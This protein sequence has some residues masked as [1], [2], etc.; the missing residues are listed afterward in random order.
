MLG[1]KIPCRGSPEAPSFSGRPEDLR[2][3]FD[4]IID[5]CD[6]FGLSDGLARIKF[7]LKYA[8]FESADLWS[9]FVSSSQGDWARFTLEITQQYP[10]LDETSRSHADELASLK[11]GFASSEVVSMSSL[12]QYYRNF[13]RISLSLENLLGPL[14]HLASMFKYGFPP[15]FRRELRRS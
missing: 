4:D 8:P 3:Y 15:E 7:A 12:G 9:H 11:V 14:P 1:F 10:E 6:G 13:R 2:S 5:F